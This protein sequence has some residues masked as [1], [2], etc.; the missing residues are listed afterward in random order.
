M[1]KSNFTEKAAVQLPLW[2]RLM[3]LTHVE[4]IPWPGTIFY[5]AVSS[6]G[7]FQ[8]HYEL[9]AGDIVKYCREGKVLDIGTGPGWLLLKLNKLVPQLQIGGLDISEVMVTK[10]KENIAGAGI[11]NNI[12][13]AQ[14]SADLLPYP[15]NYFELVVSTGSLHHW[16]NPVQG[17]NEIYRI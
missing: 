15:D 13:V 7:I 11:L 4:G 16:K 10:A 17:I 6:T 1:N 14:G 2:R 5:N 9:V 12:S 3:K 8:R